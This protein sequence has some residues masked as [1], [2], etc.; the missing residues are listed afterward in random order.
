MLSI[1]DA[2]ALMPSADPIH[3]A[4]EFCSIRINFPGGQLLILTAGRIGFHMLI[5]GAAN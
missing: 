1:P 4:V 3:H 5:H 2:A